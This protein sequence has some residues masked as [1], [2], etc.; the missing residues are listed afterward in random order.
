MEVVKMKIIF[1]LNYDLSFKIVKSDFKTL[2]K[3]GKVYL[4]DKDRI[5]EL[6]VS[7]MTMNRYKK[8]I[9]SLDS[10]TAEIHTWMLVAI[11]NYINEEVNKLL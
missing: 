3:E 8:L 5:I 1:R 7:E 10:D 2:V 11:E 4:S 6:D 9:D